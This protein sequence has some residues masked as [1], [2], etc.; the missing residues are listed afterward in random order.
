MKG[1]KDE[2]DNIRNFSRWQ[3][4]CELPDNCAEYDPCVDYPGFKN[5]LFGYKPTIKP[6]CQIMKERF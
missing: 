5:K 3:N 4:N 2:R 1:G 6:N